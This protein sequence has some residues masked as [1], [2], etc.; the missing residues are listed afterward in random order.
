MTVVL[1]CAETGE[2][3]RRYLCLCPGP[4]CDCHHTPALLSYSLSDIGPGGHSLG[5]WL[6]SLGILTMTFTLILWGIYR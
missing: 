6:L 2:E 5:D 4:T 1:H 3:C